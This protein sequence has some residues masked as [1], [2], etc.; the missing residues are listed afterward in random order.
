MGIGND[1]EQAMLAIGEARDRKGDPELTTALSQLNEIFL[2][3]ELASS[4]PVG[5]IPQLSELA[6]H[7]SAISEDS[8]RSAILLAEAMLEEGEHARDDV[9]EYLKAMNGVVVH[10]PTHIMDDISVTVAAA[11]AKAQ[12]EEEVSSEE[13]N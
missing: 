6:S 3:E 4:G 11:Q 12:A 7:F 9:R 2:G 10:G 13:R 5:I 8:R 1:F